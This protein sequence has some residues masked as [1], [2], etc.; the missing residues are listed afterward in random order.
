MKQSRWEKERQ[1]KVLA[2]ADEADS[3]EAEVEEKE[4]IGSK[5]LSAKYSINPASPW[6]GGVLYLLFFMLYLY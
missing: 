4:A 2:A 6:T 5:V 1:E 3:A